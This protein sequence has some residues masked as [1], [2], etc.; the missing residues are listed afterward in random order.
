M[1][2]IRND[3]Q[4]TIGYDLGVTTRNDLVAEKGKIN[5]DIVYVID[6]VLDYVRLAVDY[7]SQYVNDNREHVETAEETSS[8][9]L[10][11]VYSLLLFMMFTMFVGY[12]N[13]NKTAMCFGA[14]TIVS[15]LLFLSISFGIFLVI[16]IASYDTCGCD[17][18]EPS[19]YGC[20]TMLEIIATNFDYELEINGMRTSTAEHVDKLLQCPPDEDGNPGNLID[21]LELQEAFNYTS[22]IAGLQKNL[23]SA[24]GQLN[25]SVEIFGAM[26]DTMSALDQMAQVNFAIGY[27]FSRDGMMYE[28][29]AA[30]LNNPSNFPTYYPTSSP[31]KNP[32]NNPA[33]KRRVALLISEN[34]A[35]EN[36]RNNLV[37]QKAT[38]NATIYDIELSLKAMNATAIKNAKS[39]ITQS[40]SLGYLTDFISTISQ[41]TPCEFLSRYYE[42]TVLHEYCKE[43]ETTSNE[44]AVGSVVFIVALAC[45]FFLMVTMRDCVLMIQLEEAEQI[46]LKQSVQG[47][48][49]KL[50]PDRASSGVLDGEVMG[51]SRST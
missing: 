28:S 35:M 46:K 36:Q 27:N 6:M 2:Q 10:P 29:L 30:G 49:N 47:E 43:T 17:G 18:N 50:N 16:S 8:I 4:Q 9:V 48:V 13:T 32:A 34:S 5:T 1:K 3:L 33:N 26:K 20:D 38:Y 41:Y 44:T 31:T 11:I 37:V 21:I 25:V 39:L 40:Q 7:E 45:G 22:D 12:L 24:A 19:L 15:L 51:R 42:I 23:T 14:Y